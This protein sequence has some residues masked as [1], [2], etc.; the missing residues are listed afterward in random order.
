M[1]FVSFFIPLYCLVQKV[2]FEF[3]NF[4]IGLVQE[5]I[6]SLINSI[7]VP[8]NTHPSIVVSFGS[9][10]Y[11]NLILALVSRISPLK[12]SIPKDSVLLPVFQSKELELSAK[13]ILMNYL[14]EKSVNCLVFL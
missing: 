3:L 7:L 5:L 9:I 2:P 1:F 12:D 10:V 11:S 13:L 6:E 8:G 4:I 14:F